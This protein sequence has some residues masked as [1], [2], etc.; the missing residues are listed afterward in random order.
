MSRLNSSA[1]QSSCFVV[2]RIRVAMFLL[3]V[4]VL[5]MP[6]RAQ[7]FR[8]IHEFQGPEGWEPESGLTLDAAGNLYGTTYYAT[9][10]QGTVYRM[11]PSSGGWLFNTLYYFSAYNADGYF[12]D[13][14]VVFGPGGAL[15][16]TTSAGGA[17]EYCPGGC[18]VFYALRPPQTPCHSTQCLWTESVPYRFTGQYDALIP[19]RGNLIFDSA[20]NIYGT[21]EQGGQ[22]GTGTV[23]K[24]TKSNGVWIESVLYSFGHGSD[25]SFPVGGLVMDALGNLYGTTG[26]GGDL[27]C[28]GFGGE[29]CGTVFELSPSG[30]GWTE[31]VLHTFQGPD[32]SYPHATVTLGPSGEIYGGTT[33]GG[34]ANAGVLFELSPSG[35]SWSYSVLYQFQGSLDG[36]PLGPLVLDSAG[37][38]Y[39]T[40][41]AQGIYRMGSV[42][43]LAHSN[44]GWSYTTLHDFTG[45]DDGRQPWAGPALDSH[46][47]LYGTALSG[48]TG[49]CEGGRNCG[50]VWEITP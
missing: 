31:T 6:V 29:G 17:S 45:I 8:V 10:Q 14:G 43:E 30:S 37:N 9:G 46:G 50:T 41:T 24:L 19:G 5:A 4:V 47:N 3:S 28:P 18:G 15:Y 35:G 39:G 12:P 7:T 20:G 2:S 21:T 25:G 23:Y 26:L 38:L 49:R 42:F 16:G 48:G 44:G 1:A 13:S 33:D 27:S 40:T 22:Y 11:Q 34:S 32:G 36:G